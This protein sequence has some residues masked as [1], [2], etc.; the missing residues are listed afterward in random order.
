MPDPD[1]PDGRFWRWILKSDTR[2]RGYPPSAGA[3]PWPR[4]IAPGFAAVGHLE[5][6]QDVRHVDAHRLLGD[7]QAVGDPPVGEALGRGVRGPGVRTRPGRSMSRAWLA[8]ARQGVRRWA[9]VRRSTRARAPSSRICRVR[10][11]APSAP[12]AASADLSSAA[13]RRRTGPAQERVGQA[14]SGVCHRVGKAQ[15]VPAGDGICA[16]GR[17]HRTRQAAAG[18]SPLRR[19]L[20]QRS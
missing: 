2:G 13:F 10:A 8:R 19:W 5:L 3:L 1:A 17:P 4:A 11:F 14:P 18:P 6:F 16:T 15:C 12:A 7:E 9:R 20:S